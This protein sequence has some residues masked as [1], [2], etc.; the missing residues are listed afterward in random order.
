MERSLTAQRVSGGLAVIGV[1]FL[2]LA[3]Y[4]VLTEG[5]VAVDLGLALSPLVVASLV[6][7]GVAYRLRAEPPAAG[8]TRILVWAVAGSV[9]VAVAADAT[10]LRTRLFDAPVDP[11][12][13]LGGV[14]AVGAAGGGV[15]A[16]VD[17][18]SRSAATELGRQVSELEQALSAVTGVA[19]V[20]LDPEGYIVGWSEGAREL[21]G[22][23]TEDVV[24]K[25]LD[26]LYPENENEDGDGTGDRSANRDLQRAIRADGLDIEGSFERAD[27]STFDGDGTLTAMQR[28]G[29]LHGYVLVIADRTEDRERERRL[30]RQNQQLEAYASVV[31]HDL[32]NP[33]NVAIGNVQMAR[34]LDDEEPLDTAERALE[35]MEAL[36]EEVLVL[37]RQ[38]RDVGEFDRVDL[39]ECTEIAWSSIDAM[40]AEV[41]AGGL[42]TISA[43][44]ERLR[45]LFE[46][47]FRNAIEH[48]G[49]DVHVVVGALPNDEGFFVSDDGPGIPKGRR[50]EVFDAEYSTGSGGTGLGL[51]IVKGIA[52]AHGWSVTVTDS[53]SGGAR[54]EF[55]GV[56]TLA[57]V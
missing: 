7:F 35:R 2:G 15:A 6:L 16:L 50:E 49:E 52:D 41:D 56:Q 38:S 55:R 12:L 13:L 45:R 44:F 24:G 33:L 14:A 19:L 53:E 39:N 10:L 11:L 47:L 18:R 21:T 26:V 9:A 22:F 28:D 36:I 23:E 51:A 40:W 48:G 46:N 32:R 25:R 43:D 20:R 8:N 57:D 1:G 4:G 34:S 37:T 5:A 31:S 27:E 54:F 42:P 29:T 3:G 30:E 17:A